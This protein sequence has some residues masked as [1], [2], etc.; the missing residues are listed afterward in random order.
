MTGPLLEITKSAEVVP[1][2]TTL[3]VA[4][5]DVLAKFSPVSTAE[6]T[7]A[8]LAATVVATLTTIVMMADV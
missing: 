7:S 2:G 6:L 4:E 1:T 8:E 5:A 3:T